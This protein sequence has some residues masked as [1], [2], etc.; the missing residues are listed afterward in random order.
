MGPDELDRAAVKRLFLE[1]TGL[2]PGEREAF[3]DHACAGDAR[4]AAEVRSLLGF[5][6]SRTLLRPAPP[7]SP[8]RRVLA[9]AA[10]GALLLAALLADAALRRSALQDATSAL[11][12]RA[13][14]RAAAV[15]AW[16][17]ACAANVRA[18]AA[19]PALIDAAQE[20]AALATRQEP[21]AL[22]RLRAAPAAGRVADLAAQGVRDGHLD[23]LALVDRDGRLLAGGSAPG[24]PAVQPGEQLARANRLALD[25]AWRG[26]TLVLP[27]EPRD[28]R[29]GGSGA[30]TV[31]AAAA[32][33]AP[34]GEHPAALVVA[35]PWDAA[36]LAGG[37][38]A[39]GEAMRLLDGRGRECGAAAAGGDLDRAASEIA[40]RRS[41]SSSA[42]YAD[43]QGTPVIG[44][45]RWLEAEGV[46][47]VAERR[48]ADV[49]A[50][51]RSVQ[52]ALLLL[53]AGAATY[54]LL[55][56]WRTARDARPPR[57]VRP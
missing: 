19:D 56:V 46:G 31:Y 23:L 51:L 36:L 55:A 8:R 21:D 29:G 13:D 3:L 30:L 4:L 45:W 41:G 17:D 11:A 7:P 15:A 2:P 48:L 16:M 42:P 6:D 27:P 12:T 53:L 38:A 37:E 35:F 24:M 40:A 52:A 54:L 25:D 18:R 34:G 39:P 33:V 32:L 22:A 14:E 50:P 28:A 43:A 44:A 47:V 10:V 57:E 26:A 9:L 1:A 49:L 5:H 20:L